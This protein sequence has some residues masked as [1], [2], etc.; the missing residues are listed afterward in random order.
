MY[1]LCVGI[2]GPYITP[3]TLQWVSCNC[4]SLTSS[5]HQPV[6]WHRYG[7][8]YPIMLQGIIMHLPWEWVLVSERKLCIYKSSFGISDVCFGTKTQ[9]RYTDQQ[10]NELHVCTE[11]LQ[12][13]YL[14]LHERYRKHN[15]HVNSLRATQNL[16]VHVCTWCLFFTTCTICL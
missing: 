9:Y 3:T 7:I 6:C 4:L 8:A 1:M 14:S 13:E 11:L 16:L 10:C 2:L 15:K 5:V 12:C